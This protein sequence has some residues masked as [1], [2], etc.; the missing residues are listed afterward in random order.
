MPAVKKTYAELEDEAKAQRAR[1]TIQDKKNNAKSRGLV[2]NEQPRRIHYR[3]SKYK[4]PNRVLFNT[5]PPSGRSYQEIW[6]DVLRKICMKK[7]PKEVKLI[8][9]RLLCYD[10]SVPEMTKTGI[11]FWSKKTQGL[12]EDFKA[13]YKIKTVDEAGSIKLDIDK[14]SRCP[15]QEKE[16]MIFRTK[17]EYDKM[18]DCKERV[19]IQV[20]RGGSAVVVSV[21]PDPGS[22]VTMLPEALLKDNS[23]GFVPEEHLVTTVTGD[24]VPGYV[25]GFVD[26]DLSFPESYTDD[27]EGSERRFRDRIYVSKSQM[28]LLGKFFLR[29]YSYRL[30]SDLLELRDPSDEQKLYIPTRKPENFSEF[31]VEI[32]HKIK[33]GTKK[34]VV[35]RSNKPVPPNCN[36]SHIYSYLP[37][38]EVKFTNVKAIDSYRVKMTVVN[39]SEGDVNLSA[40][41]KTGSWQ[42]SDLTTT[43]YHLKF[44]CP[45]HEIRSFSAL[46]DKK[47]YGK[48][49]LPDGNFY[50]TM[51]DLEKMYEQSL[52][53][54]RQMQYYT[55]DSIPHDKWRGDKED[56]NQD[57]PL[58]N[59]E[60]KVF[61]AIFQLFEKGGEFDRK[62]GFSHVL[63][64]DSV[65]LGKFRGKPVDLQLIDEG[66]YSVNIKPQSNAS[67]EG[68]K[69]CEAA[70]NFW[71]ELGLWEPNG[72]YV[73]GKWEPEL[74]HSNLQLRAIPKV[75]RNTSAANKLTKKRTD[76]ENQSKS[77]VPE[78]YTGQG[79]KLAFRFVINA[80]PLNAV[81]K[82][83]PLV[84]NNAAKSRNRNYL[85][86]RITVC[87]VFQ[88]FSTLELSENSRPWCSFTWKGQSWSYRRGSMGISEM[89]SRWQ[90]ANLQMF[91]DDMFNEV[92]R[93]YPERVEPGWLT[94][95]DVTEF[96]VDD[97]QV[98]TLEDKNEEITCQRHANALFCVFY[99][100]AKHGITVKT[101]QI[102]LFSTRVTW[103]GA[104]IDTKLGGMEMPEEKMRKLLGYHRPA[105]KHELAS[106]TCVW[107]YYSTTCVFLRQLSIPLLYT[108]Q[109]EEEFHWGKAQQYAY[110]ECTLMCACSIRINYMDEKYPAFLLTDISKIGYAGILLQLIHG[111][112][113]IISQHSKIFTRT[114]R[115]QAPASKELTANGAI[116]KLDEPKILFHPQLVYNVS[117]CI[118]LVWLHRLNSF[119]V[120]HRELAAYLDQFINL[121]P[122]H[123]PGTNHLIADL[124]S[125]LMTY[126][127]P[128]ENSNM[129][130]FQSEFI[131]VN[132][133]P[134]A[135]MSPK[136]F[137]QLLH[138]T[139][140]A[141]PLFDC[142]LYGNRWKTDEG[143]PTKL[144]E[145]VDLITHTQPDIRFLDRILKGWNDDQ[146]PKTRAKELAEAQR[147]A[148]LKDIKTSMPEKNRFVEASDWLLDNI[149]N[150]YENYLK[151]YM[152]SESK[153]VQVERL[154]KP[155]NWKMFYQ[156][157][158]RSK[159]DG[160][161]EFQ[162]LAPVRRKPR[163]KPESKIEAE[164]PAPE[165]VEEEINWTNFDDPEKI[166]VLVE[167]LKII[168]EMEY[169]PDSYAKYHKLYHQV[170]EFLDNPSEKKYHRIIKGILTEYDEIAENL[171][172]VGEKYC[173]TRRNV[174]LM[175]CYF[176]YPEDQPPRIHSP[177]DHIDLRA[178]E[179]KEIQPM[180][181]EKFNTGIKAFLPRGHFGLLQPRSSLG[182][183]GLILLATTID[184]QYHGE[185]FLLI[186]NATSSSV[187][188][189]KTDYL[190][191]FILT[192]YIGTE[193]K[194]LPADF[195]LKSERGDK[196]LGSSDLVRLTDNQENHQRIEIDAKWTKIDR[197]RLTKE[198]KKC[199][200]KTECL[201]CDQLASRTTEPQDAD[202]LES[203]KNQV[204]SFNTVMAELIVLETKTELKTLNKIRKSTLNKL[205]ALNEIMGSKGVI[206]KKLFVDLQKTDEHLLKL[207]KKAEKRQNLEKVHY[208]IEDEVLYMIEPSKKGSIKKLCCPLV[209]L[210]K[211]MQNI[212]NSKFVHPNL[213]QLKLM[214][215]K[216][217][218]HPLIKTVA[219]NI[220][221]ECELC[222]LG[223]K[224][225][226]KSNI[227]TE[228]T[229]DKEKRI[230]A[231]LFADHLVNL[232]PSNGFLH[233]L[234][235]V[236][237]ISNRCVLYPCKGL[238]GDEVVKHIKNYVNHMGPMKVFRSDNHGAF[239]SYQFRQYLASKNILFHPTSA[240]SAQSNLAE[241]VIK[242]VKAVMT[243][244]CA[245][246]GK[247]KT[248]SYRLGEIANTVN[249][250]I[251][252]DDQ[253]GF[254]PNE[255]FFGPQSYNIMNFL[256][257]EETDEKVLR[258]EH[259]KLI[260]RKL[261][262]R[263]GRRGEVPMKKLLRNA[264]S[265]G[266]IVFFHDPNIP[267]VDKSKALLPQSTLWMIMHV[268]PSSA[269]LCNV[270][271]GEVRRN[272]SIKYIRLANLRE[273][274][275]F[276]GIDPRNLY[277]GMNTEIKKQ[278][279]EAVHNEITTNY[280]DEF[281]QDLGGPSL[282]SLVEDKNWREI[283]ELNI[284]RVC[285]YT[286]R[287]LKQ[288]E[289]EKIKIETETRNLRIVMQPV[290]NLISAF[291]NRQKNCK[292]RLRRKKV[293]FS[294][295]KTVEFDRKGKMF[296][297]KEKEFISETINLI[298]KSSQFT[299][300]QMYIN[301]FAKTMLPFEAKIAIT[302]D[303]EKMLKVK[304]AKKAYQK[305]QE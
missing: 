144:P 31:A 87:D 294:E 91:S 291:R 231:I 34:E 183:K 272:V 246:P 44:D 128:A 164:K 225:A 10:S 79:D 64:C 62:P 283:N 185:I 295:V 119:E 13:K 138:S 199:L 15:I 110:E 158:S 228:R 9:D 100:L 201:G 78:R 122:V 147:E 125:R 166:I 202:W 165:P 117:D 177:G 189:S 171:Q 289:T 194:H 247:R 28:Y 67:Y 193:I 120:K 304:L 302:G 268:Y 39:E 200:R 69:A 115:R 241:R 59:W 176:Q 182:K 263:A 198:A 102:R 72:K 112:I 61:R 97:F 126:K 33:S 82:C 146:V 229:Y 150:D 93:K 227:G 29:N 296:S 7:Y 236:E 266:E 216:F 139:A 220:T 30:S 254:S 133:P 167:H 75:D 26:V 37:N 134:M 49:Y 277:Q 56:E 43:W 179:S 245:Y 25:V 12:V 68:D 281:A 153:Y 96:F 180:Q 157:R 178:G 65:D 6:A 219:A 262:L 217:L 255:V 36:E 46:T 288:Q 51:P 5:Y 278:A 192:R 209:L 99:T 85:N 244:I 284:N 299:L 224:Q 52:D 204:S 282:R 53:F 250:Q 156:T 149:E 168:L 127:E 118:G 54:D 264:Y 88:A 124:M 86:C 74:S 23:I 292:E 280:F 76:A 8:I 21:L 218:Y 163:S 111:E 141:E 173:W 257:T 20:N 290:K 252:K 81:L 293:Q 63:M 18:K 243:R 188:V 240:Y 4:V 35:I 195:T 196:S 137:H 265:P 71:T 66:K 2:D 186:Y 154:R 210:K 271:T 70:F 162:E 214:T 208:L 45:P 84:Y 116:V 140:T 169:L 197:K 273:L 95:S 256:M 226:T 143:I 107:S 239:T 251:R 187:K 221:G 142:S 114:Q 215:R 22:D 42:E 285:L 108:L 132:F 16:V 233:C 237:Q 152:D 24:K 270:V 32:D 77:S 145:F 73:N 205:K 135:V 104:T 274:D 160:E 83:C 261:K 203:E 298:G 249:N 113:R 90:L 129:S 80:K 279:G 286:K 207:M 17:D 161:V 223:N 175:P 136:Q 269:D 101:H 98:V 181:I 11:P 275:M 38:T 123:H 301:T 151:T 172:K 230:G 253:D 191:N 131:N 41:V 159:Q 130:K 211:V 92:K 106:I 235:L 155:S 259:R 89:P 260:K 58:R 238:G 303:E 55:V 242:E 27:R 267:T 105:S 234:I 258:K 50:E 109:C 103:L 300:E 287:E 14:P 48:E 190:V 19:L 60:W 222:L 40:S 248:W 305:T 206:K 148:I 94:Y 232:S 121:S 276:A 212:H 174:P 57:T 1:K 47:M 170:N 3:K 213:Q 184:S 297:N